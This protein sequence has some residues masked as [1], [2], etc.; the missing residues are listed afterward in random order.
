MFLKIKSVL[1]LI[2]PKC[3]HL[4]P[5]GVNFSIGNKL[6]EQ[7]EKM[8]I[9]R[10]SLQHWLKQQQKDLQPIQLQYSRFSNKCHKQSNKIALS[11][12]LKLKMKTVKKRNK[13]NKNKMKNNHTIISIPYLLIHF[14]NQLRLSKS[15][16][17]QEVTI[18]L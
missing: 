5:I 8:K 1:S 13:F 10:N 9:R 16:F 12:S 18:I 17:F 2:F 14:M 7:V 3:K 15:H 4:M 6:A 11:S